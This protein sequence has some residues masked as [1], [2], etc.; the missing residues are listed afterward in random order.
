MLGT[1]TLLTSDARRVKKA[2]EIA[3]DTL[4]AYDFQFEVE[5]VEQA[6]ETLQTVVG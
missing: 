6:I 3:R 5:K 4:E 2:L 1:V